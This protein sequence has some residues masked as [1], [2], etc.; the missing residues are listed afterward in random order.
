VVIQDYGSGLDETSLM[1]AANY[2][3]EPK[4]TLIGKNTTGISLA[5]AISGFYSGAQSATL[6]F[7]APFAAGRYLFQVRSGGIIDQAG[8]PLDGEFTGRLPSGTGRPGG[9]FLVQIHVHGRPATR[10]H[11]PHPTRFPAPGRR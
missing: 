10:S 5:P 4:R 3:I 1:N 2:T 8:N 9:N 6:H 11:V 7:Q